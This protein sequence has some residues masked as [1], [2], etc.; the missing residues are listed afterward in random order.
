MH[1]DVEKTIAEPVPTNL[2]N[3]STSLMKASG[4]GEGYQHAH[5]FADAIP[6]MECLP[7][8]AGRA[9]SLADR[10]R[11]GEAGRRAAGGDQAAEREEEIG[12]R[13][14]SPALRL[15]VGK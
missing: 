8:L 1:E 10:S 3:A 13:V 6:Y 2:R 12:S 15:N 14:G 9:L 7:A 11:S 5:Q 4:Y